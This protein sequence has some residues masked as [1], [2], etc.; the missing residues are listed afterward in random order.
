MV[1]ISISVLVTAATSLLALT[2]SAVTV[3]SVKKEIV[4]DGPT[5]SQDNAT[6]IGIN[7]KQ[8]TIIGN[9]GSNISAN[10]SIV[11]PALVTMST[12]S[13]PAVM[14][15]TK[16]PQKVSEATTKSIT[17]TTLKPRSPTPKPIEGTVRY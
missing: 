6:I 8:L 16:L 4:E 2:D 3:R 14:T 9:S 11:A 17:H 5:I 15:T 1:S 10:S 13:P 7:S 12:V